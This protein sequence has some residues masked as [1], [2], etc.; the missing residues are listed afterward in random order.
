MRI[1]E[2]QIESQDLKDDLSQRE[3]KVSLLLS[4][5]GTWG[6]PSLKLFFPQFVPKT[7]GAER[8]KRQCA[9]RNDDFLIML[10][11]PLPPPPLLPALIIHV[12]DS[13]FLAFYCESVMYGSNVKIYAV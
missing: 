1:K 12:R 9:S 8:T 11:L 5:M 3:R 6:I 4:V 2:L 10:A 13:S 7:S